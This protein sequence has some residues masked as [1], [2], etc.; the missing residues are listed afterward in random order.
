MNHS[1]ADYLR[2]CKEAI[3]GKF[4]FEQT[5]EGLRQRDLE[6]LA[7]E[8]EEKSGI[9]LSLSTLKR[10]WKKDYD[11]MPH[12]S[13]L[14]ALVSIIGYKDWQAFKLA[15]SP[16]IASSISAKGNAQ[17]LFRRWMI[18]PIGL[19]LILLIWLIGIRSTQA[20]KLKPQVKGPVEFTGNKTVSQGVPNTVV[21]NYDLTHVV[22]D[23]FFFQQSWNEMERV[24][25]DPREHI[26]SNIYYYPGFHR[27]KLI[28]ND[29]IIS[30]FRVH[31]T[32]DGW[33]PLLRY[34][35]LDNVPVYLKNERHIF[36][37]A[38]HVQREELVSSKIDLNKAFL[39]SYFNVRE[40]DSVYSDQFS[41]DTRIK[42]DSFSTAPCPGFDLTMIFEEHIFYVRMMGR[43]CEIE[44]AVKMGEVSQ[45]GRKS[46]LRALGRDLYQWQHLQ[47]Q[48][49]NK[50]ATIFLD[51][52]PV[53]S[54]QF[55]NDFGKL[56]GLAYHFTGTGAID[57]VKLKNGKNKL[58]YDE[59]FDQ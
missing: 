57:F 19:A 24:K 8:I 53:H 27:A 35:F 2:M 42:S 30:R 36:D 54:V 4:Q 16:S 59:T 15:Q 18:L 23:S 22:A 13:T 43:G 58:V 6:W 25:L 44:N 32:T 51:E 33:L 47:I 41:L 45:D 40:F 37:G 1:E 49:Q 48:V 55:K 11:Q 28:A 21:F 50:L 14:Q 26:Y 29:S 52:K 3:E 12:P 20:V 39:L 5:G 34:S 56:V 17:G 46:D 10:I 38:L 9:K 7:D 31:I